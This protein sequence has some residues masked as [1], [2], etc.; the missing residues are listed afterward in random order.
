V[1]TTIPI[2]EVP[3]RALAEA[4]LPAIVELAAGRGW[5]PEHAK[6]RLMF[7][8]SEPYGVDDP[9]GGLAGVVVVTRYGCEL[10]AVGMMLVASRHGGQGLGRRLMEHALAVAG[11]ATV[12][13]TATAEGRPLYERVGFRAADQSVTYT[14]Q[15][16]LDLA[17]ELPG[18]PRQVTA[19]DVDHIAAADRE[20]F[21]ADRRRVLAELVTFADDFV[22]LPAAPDGYAACWRKDGVRVI[23]PVVAA[24]DRVGRGLV[25]SLALRGSGP[26]RL[27]ILGRHAGLARWAAASG[28]RAGSTTTLMIRGQRIPGDRS[29]LYCP[30][31]VAIG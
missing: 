17:G 24:S 13:L 25:T 28:L 1:T 23:G 20:V 27:D 3:V 7:A 11:D 5:P 9:A 18:I 22:M 2:T 6:W 15:L 19:A 12:Y 8:V 16:S 21:G 31:S 26:V 30:V 14:G 10:A 4:D 29:R